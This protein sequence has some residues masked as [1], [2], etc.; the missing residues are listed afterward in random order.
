MPAAILQQ[1][2][3]NCGCLSTI[4]F[5]PS[6]GI[7]CNSNFNE[8]P[9]FLVE[10]KQFRQISPK[11]HIFLVEKNQIIVVCPPHNLDLYSAIQI[12][13]PPLQFCELGSLAVP[14][15]PDG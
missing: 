11:N 13:T 4:K 2:K 9:K 6:N 12:S 10:P 3:S 14:P 7:Q 8:N 15:E 1:L 5:R